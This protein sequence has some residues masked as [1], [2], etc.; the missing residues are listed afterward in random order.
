MTDGA[1]KIESVVTLDCEAMAIVR[2]VGGALMLS[3]LPPARPQSACA[4]SRVP[5]SRGC[6]VRK[7]AALAMATVVAAA[8]LIMALVSAF[9][10]AQAALARPHHGWARAARPRHQTVHQT[11]QEKYNDAAPMI[12]GGHPGTTAFDMAR[13]MAAVLAASSGV[14]LIA[15]DASGGI[16]S[17]R[18]LLLLRGIDLALVP[19][20]VLDAAARA[21][22]LGRDLRERL[23]Y[24]AVLYGEEVPRSC[25]RR[26]TLV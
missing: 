25:R 22:T 8:F 21:E 24:V 1:G 4:K 17:L 5:A 3:I 23:A 7:P 19:R 11:A 26:R 14:R 9:T 13:D 16:D 12:L 6:S 15:V 20:N 2:Q 10:A 18:D